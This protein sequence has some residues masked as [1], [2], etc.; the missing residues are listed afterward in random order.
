MFQEF[1]NVFDMTNTQITL[2]TLLLTL[3]FLNFYV[4]QNV[5]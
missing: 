1:N 2:K 5:R 4:E 3:S